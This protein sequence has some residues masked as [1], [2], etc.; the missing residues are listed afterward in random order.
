MPAF[1]AIGVAVASAAGLVGTAAVIGGVG[2]SWLGVAVATVTA[3]GASYVASRI[4]G[5]SVRSGAGMATDASA[6]QGGRVQLPPATNNKIPVLYGRGFINGVVT[7]A[8]L[9]STDQKT[10]NV[11]YY[12]LVLSETSNA[13]GATYTVNDIYWNDLR[14]IAETSAGNQHKILKGVKKVDGPGEDF[15]DTNFKKDSN[16]VQMRVYAGNSGAAR[17]I[18]PLPSTGNQ[19]N[20]W[21]FWPDSTWT[22]ANQMQ[23]LVFAVIR[24]EYDQE[25]GFVNLPAVTFDITNSVSNPALVWQDYMTSSRFGA[26]L[27]SN[28]LDLTAVTQWRDFCDEQIT[29]TNK[30]GATTLQKRY[31]INGPVDTNRS[32]KDNIDSIL[33]NGG[34]WMSYD[35][36]DARWRPI[37]KKAITAGDPD[38]VNTHFTANVVP[39]TGSNGVPIGDGLMTV[40]AFPEGRIEA[41]QE[42]VGNIAAGTVIVNQITP[43]TAGETFGQKGRYRITTSAT[44]TNQKFYCLASGL[45][46]FT[47]S[48]IISGITISSTR[49]EDLYNAYEVEFFD[50]HNKDQRSYARDSLPTSALN[51]Q[52]QPNTLTFGLDLCNNSVQAALIGGMELRQ[53]RDDLMIEFTTSHYGI[54]AQAG[55]VISVVN[56]I[57]G[58]APKLF[59]VTRIKETE[60][61]E[62]LLLATIQALEYNGDVYTIEPLTE[63]TTEANIGIPPQI[64]SSNLVTPDDNGV[65]ITDVNDD[66]AVPNIVIGVEVPATGGPYDE[67]QVWYA[68][69]PT[70][71]GFPGDNEYRWIQSTK[72]PGNDPIFKGFRSLT[73]TTITGGNTISNGTAHGLLAGDAMM[74]KDPSTNGLQFNKL[75]YVLD[76]GLTTTSFRL[77]REENGAAVTLTNGTGLSLDFN[78]CQPVTIV[79]LPSNAPGQQ[80]YF[81]VRVGLRGYYSGYTNPDTA[82]IAAAQFIPN[83]VGGGVLNDLEDVVITNPV[84]GELLYYNGTVWVNEHDIRADSGAQV[85]NH[86]RTATAAD[87][88]PTETPKALELELRITDAPDNTTNDGGPSLMFN[89]SFGATGNKETFGLVG[90]AYRGSDLNHEFRVLTTTDGFTE[91]P[92]D[93]YPNATN[94]IVSSRVGTNINSGVLYVDKTNSRVGINNTAPNF[95][96]DISGNAY[97]SDDLVVQGGDIT[98]GSGI[99]NIYN[100]SGIGTVNMGD[101]ATTEVNI[102]GLSTPRVQIKPNTIVGANTTQN[103]FNTVATTV[104]AFGAATAVN[105]GAATGTTTIAHDLTVNG[106]NINLN[107][108]A[109]AA[110]QPFITFATQPDGVNS[111]YGIRGTSTVDD[112]W[113]IGAGST[114]DDGGYLEIATGDNSGGTNTGGQIYVRQYDGSSPKTGAPWFGG[115]GSIVHQLTLLDNLGHTIIPNNLTV[116]SGTLFVDSANNRVGVRTLTPQYDLDVT[117][118]LRLTGDIRAADGLVNISM[119]SNTRTTFAGDIRING[120][121]IRASDD[122]INITLESNQKTTFA[123]D[124]RVNGNDIRA[125]DDQINI[126]LDSNDNTTFAGKITV[127]GGRVESPARL[128]LDPGTELAI[129]A[130]TV[131][132]VHSSGILIFG[133]GSTDLTIDTNNH[134]VGIFTATPAYTLDVN[135]TA[136]TGDLI[137]NGAIT[138][139][140]ITVINDI[141]TTLGAVLA[142]GAT[143]GA[144]DVGTTVNHMSLTAGNYTNPNLTPFNI[145]GLNTSDGFGYKYLIKVARP[146]GTPGVGAW[147]TDYHLIE[148]MVVTSD[149]RGTSPSVTPKIS[150]GNEVFSNVKLVGSITATSS[151]GI[152]AI[153]ITPLYSGMTTQWLLIS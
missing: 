113:F 116:D 48:N 93:T 65:V 18:W 153:T 80:Y 147:G 117:G 97:I 107:G 151:A 43:L 96:L 112:P 142:P 51:T 41:G 63:F 47:D 70:T 59:R 28:D 11:M 76:A 123:G 6:N 83:P 32:V 98:T 8:R 19:Q 66:V 115:N 64:S 9:I 118:D 122:Q 60:T 25:N 10:N 131:E 40:T 137:A 23:G 81:R 12:C 100:N 45:L 150:I 20:A 37:I 24:L 146:Y 27:V 42:M 88:S 68:T 38:D 46:E 130:P 128:T 106:G 75:Y 44:V 86:V 71:P 110:Q 49:L 127:N 34:A 95:T 120:N 4:I 141:K 39:G 21:D 14:L 56:D 29:F 26:G 89:R 57:Y 16:R 104:N 13:A 101:G 136:R 114:G 90:M 52:E 109:I 36:A 152:T 111:M 91:N 99:A 2:L 17:Q 55:D 53:G 149:T 144:I 119:T 140:S 77:G 148:M 92:A 79:T 129:D 108:N 7:D 72:P 132:I 125:S 3:I 145:H 135:G 33:R 31:E 62:G 84:K 67:I 61:D 133:D 5:G 124:I 1:T 87:Q 102:G 105:I 94:L 139:N 143:I 73:F 138:G 58:W 121:D 54:Q 74:F 22:S 15:E 35:V 69:G 78:T 103:V 134:R 50:K 85:V 126:T 30:D 82:V